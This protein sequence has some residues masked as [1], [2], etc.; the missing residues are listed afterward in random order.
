MS[1]SGI[2]LAT[3]R[4]FT[5]DLRIRMDP[6]FELGRCELG[7]LVQGM[8]RHE[9]R[10][11]IRLWSSMQC[12]RAPPTRSRTTPAFQLQDRR[13]PGNK[14]R[15]LPGELTCRNDAMRLIRHCF[16]L[17]APARARTPMLRCCKRRSLAITRCIFLPE[18]ACVV[19]KLCVEC[20]FVW[21]PIKA[22]LPLLVSAPAAL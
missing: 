3:L 7:W 9:P 15:Q 21:T 4:I 11:L 10:A 17:P 1:G 6:N 16:T 13:S 22:A 5:Q 18:A 14:Q 12:G 8:L 19:T 20:L 2:T